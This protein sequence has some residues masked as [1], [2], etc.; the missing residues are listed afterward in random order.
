MQPA[1]PADLAGAHA[2]SL[3]FSTDLDAFAAAL[4]Y[5]KGLTTSI[6]SFVAHP[7]DV[8]SILNIKEQSGSVK[9]LL[10]SDPT[11]PTGRSVFG[12]PLFST[13]AVA[14]G[15]V[16]GIPKAHTFLV[17]REDATL[18]RSDEAYFS[19]DRVAVRAI[20][21]AGFGFTYADAVAKITAAA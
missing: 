13:T 17:I 15:T 12:K 10:G 2:Y 1:G 20:T 9:P 7:D 5:A 19:S 21:R 18:T 6:D 3:G 4:V 11:A 8:L 16:W 14:K